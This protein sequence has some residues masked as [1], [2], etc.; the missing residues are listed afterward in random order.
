MYAAAG[1]QTANADGKGGQNA[2][3][4]TLKIDDL[5]G[6]EPYHR[7]MEEL[8]PFVLS[9]EPAAGSQVPKLSG[10]RGWKALEVAWS[11]GIPLN[12]R[13]VDTLQ[14]LAKEF[15]LSTPRSM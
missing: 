12:G 1:F 5:G 15:G 8:I 7:M 11:E 10:A 3:I 4:F 14:G 6:L 9:S 2:H 13:L